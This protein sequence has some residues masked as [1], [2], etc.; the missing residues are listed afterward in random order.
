MGPSPVWIP[1]AG[2]RIEAAGASAAS[3]CDRLHRLTATGFSSWEL[4]RVLDI[5]SVCRT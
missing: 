4:L 5:L 1:E 3:R 2:T